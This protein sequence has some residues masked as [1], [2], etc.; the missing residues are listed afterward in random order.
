MNYKMIGKILSKLL[1]IEVAFMVPALALCLYD[2]SAAA[3]RGYLG[4]MAATLAAAGILH[5]ACRNAR[6]GFYAREGLVLTGLAWIIMSMLGCLPFYLSGEIPSYIDALFEMVSGFTTTGSSILSEVESLSRGILYWRSFSH[7][8]GGMGVLV[9]LMAI[10]PLSGKNEGFTLHILRAE[11]PGP[12]VGKMVPRMKQT[13]QILYGIYVVLTVLDVIFLMIGGMPW[14]EALCHAFGT[15]GTGG[16]GVKNDSYGSYSP[17]LVNVTT[18]FMLLFGVNF[19]CYYLLLLK[20]FRDV[21]ADEE[22]RTYIGIVLGSTVLITLGI[23]GLYPTL[24][25]AIRHAAF[26]VGSIISTTGYA[27]ADTNVWPPFVKALMMFLMI[28]GASAG[29]TGGGMKVA[30]IILAMKALRRNVHEN[31]H[32]TEISKVRFNKAPMDERVI[33]NLNGYLIAYFAIIIVSFLVVSLDGFSVETN[34]SAVLATFNNIGP[35]FDA[36]GSTSNFGAYG[37]LSKLVF[38]AD[39]LAGRLEIFP[40]LILASR[41]TWTRR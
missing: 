5:L 11:S 1:L 40:I 4:G 36:V 20:R 18:V 14:F 9:F 29:S 35:G 13:A 25:E 8:V 19:S 23:R 7:W 26:Q 37:V 27:T 41:S 10:V 38:I 34:I 32:P 22:L 16:F 28:C 24:S 21:F 39:M 17:Y 6:P 12:S 31:L 3:T 15:A 30:R 2:G 33:K